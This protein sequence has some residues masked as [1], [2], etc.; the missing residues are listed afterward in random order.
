MKLV[1]ATFL[2]AV[3]HAQKV[4]LRGS[5]SRELQ[6]SS[7]SQ[8]TP[9]ISNWTPIYDAVEASH[10]VTDHSPDGIGWLNSWEPWDG[11]V[12]NPNNYGKRA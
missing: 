2:I 5:T 11:T 7:P 6:T 10:L 4:A 1:I 12:L 8:Y 3:A 9:D